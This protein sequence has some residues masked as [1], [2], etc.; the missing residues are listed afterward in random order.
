MFKQKI[1]PD[2]LEVAGQ[3]GVVFTAEAT[4]AKSRDTF[5]LIMGLCHEILTFMFYFSNGA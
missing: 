4:D 5:P 1:M 2:G 3:P